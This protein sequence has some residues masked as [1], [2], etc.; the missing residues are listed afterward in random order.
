MALTVEGVQTVELEGVAPYEGALPVIVQGGV[1]VNPR[2]TDTADRSGVFTN[3]GT[4]VE[5]IPYRYHWFFMLQN[6]SDSPMWFN[7][8]GGL[9]AGPE[10]AGSFLLTAGSPP[11]RMENVRCAVSL[12][13]EADGARWAAVTDYT[14]DGEG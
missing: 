14:G 9:S 2:F 4:A 3:G 6:V 12:Y 8:Q 10:T 7:L 13:S 1:T 11:F 5:A